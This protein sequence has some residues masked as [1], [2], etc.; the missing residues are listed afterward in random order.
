MATAW[1]RAAGLCIQMWSC[2]NIWCRAA[3]YYLIKTL[4]L[5]PLCGVL[6]H[7]TPPPSTAPLP[8]SPATQQASRAHDKRDLYN[9]CIVSQLSRKKYCLNQA[10]IKDLVWHV[11]GKSADHCTNGAEKYCPINWHYPRTRLSTYSIIHVLDY[12]RT[13]LSTYSINLQSRVKLQQSDC[14]AHLYI[15]RE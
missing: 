13:R 14:S 6:L 7:C 8:P 11:P 10:A 2:N 12:P 4:W 9:T 1:S 3:L 15:K 5:I